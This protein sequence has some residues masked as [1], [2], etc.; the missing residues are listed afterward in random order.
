MPQPPGCSEA[1]EQ[2]IDSSRC[3]AK[4]NTT[5]ELLASLLVSQVCGSFAPLFCYTNA[6][7]IDAIIAAQQVYYT[8]PGLNNFGSLIAIGLGGLQGVNYNFTIT[9]T[10]ANQR[11]WI[12]AVPTGAECFAVA[13]LI[14]RCGGAFVSKIWNASV[15]DTPPAA[16]YPGVIVS[17][18]CAIVGS[19]VWV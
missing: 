14:I 1:I 15:G 2:V 10:D 12:S 9:L 4:Q 3:I 17:P 13:A 7:E 19:P 8:G 16:P 18:G 6:E 11:A 5:N